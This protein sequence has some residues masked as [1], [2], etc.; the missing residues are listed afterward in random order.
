MAKL[1]TGLRDH[2]LA[3]GSLKSGLDGGVIYIYSGTVPASADVA[4]SGNTLLCTISDDATGTGIN[5]AASPASG[6]LGKDAA[7]V[8][9]GL[10]VANGLAT[11]YRFS[12][13]SDAGALSTT[14]K[15]L[16]GTIAT[17]GADLI[18][19]NVNFVSGNYKNVDSFNV[20]LPTA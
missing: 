12:S 19:S 13:L 6:V 15:R 3:S 14:E 20:A 16:Q 9:R 7:E 4:L 10:I 2:M 18:F 1:S 8:W 5:M 11:F 17:V